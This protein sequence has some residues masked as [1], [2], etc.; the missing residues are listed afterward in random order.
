MAY[1]TPGRGFLVLSAALLLG[2]LGPISPSRAVSLSNSTVVNPPMP[3]PIV[4]VAPRTLNAD[5]AAMAVAVDSQGNRIAAGYL[6][7]ATPGSDFTVAKFGLFGLLWQRTLR[8]S[9]GGWD[10]AW[11]VAVDGQNNIYAAGSTTNTGTGADL[12]VAK[13]DPAGNLLWSR[14]VDGGVSRFDAATSLVIDSGGNP[15][16]AG[17]LTTFYQAEYYGPWGYYSPERKGSD[18]AV[19]KWDAAGNPFEGFRAGS[20][21]EPRRA[22]LYRE[23]DE[24]A[25]SVAID[26]QDN[27][28]AAGRWF[29][30]MKWNAN[31]RPAW[32]Q[33]YTLGG[34][35]NEFRSVAVDSQDN[36]LA[37]GIWFRHP[38]IWFESDVDW[39]IVKIG[40]DGAQQ[41]RRDYVTPDAN[42]YVYNEATS[43]AVDSGDNVLVGGMLDHQFTVVKLDPMLSESWKTVVTAFQGAVNAV[44]VGP[45]DNVYA[46]GYRSPGNSNGNREFTLVSLDPSGAERWRSIYAS[47]NGGYGGEAY[48]VAVNSQGRSAAAGNVWLA[49]SGSR[50]A[51]T[52]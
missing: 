29:T 2:A 16:A 6:W 38:V 13:W 24:G 12:T 18:M 27:I 40:P 46:A 48:A 44:A 23:G 1:T 32:T 41:S 45:G 14:S 35:L 20:R 39:T 50:F 33:P 42:G 34:E 25:L 52:Y 11:A 49:G 5:G 22:S 7:N 43:L 19:M 51:V 30:V 26:H 15:V 47:P 8:G 4:Y 10:A 21:P 3:Q 17:T 37:A 28:I 36:I 31:G 9:A